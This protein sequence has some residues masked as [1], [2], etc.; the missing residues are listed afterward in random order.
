MAQK[1]LKTVIWPRF[2]ESSQLLYVVRQA[3]GR[4]FWPRCAPKECLP[5]S[6]CLSSH[7]CPP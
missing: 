6:P 4:S 2:T 7:G 1:R 5:R 3:L